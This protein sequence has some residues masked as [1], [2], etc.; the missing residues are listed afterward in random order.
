[1][2]VSY[3]EPRWWS[4]NSVPRSAKAMG[5]QSKEGQTAGLARKVI[6]KEKS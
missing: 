1:M 5:R 6:Y 3:G 2:S 4:L